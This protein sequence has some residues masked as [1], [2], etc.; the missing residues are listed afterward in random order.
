[1][2]QLVDVTGLRLQHLIDGAWTDGGADAAGKQ[3]AVSTNPANAD[4]VAT[5][6]EAT[7]ADLR[8]SLDAAVQA[9]REWSKAGMIRRGL[10]LR[11]AAE[12]LEQRADQVARLM[13]AEEGKTLPEARVE[14]G[15]SVE[16]LHYHAGQSRMAEGSI[17]PSSHPDE[18]I[19]TVRRPLGVVAVI[20]PW[21]FPVQI[22]VWKIAPALLW[23]NAVIWKPASETPA[24][25]VALAQVFLDA[26]VPAGVLNLLLAP[27]SLGAELVAAEEVAAVTF[28][29]S[30]P[31]GRSIAGVAIP[32]GARV[33]LELGGHNAAIVM[34]D[35]DP[36]VAA[37]TLVFGA[38]GSTGQKCTATRR[39]IAV[40]EMY[41]ALIPEL[42]KRVEALRV[43]DGAEGGVDIGPLISGRSRKDVQDAVDTAIQQGAE[44][45]ASTPGTPDGEAFF[46]PTV[47]TGPATMDI[48]REEVFGPVTTLLRAADLDE[49]IEL[50]NGTKFGL[51]ASI[52]SSDERTVRRCVEEIDAGLV[53]ANAPTT[54]SELHVPFGGTKASAFP[55]PREQNA[56]TAADF[57]TWSKSAYMRTAA[58]WRSA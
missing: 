47:L 31:V 27:G 6:R 15:A 23:G 32:R 26:G 41:D 49:A 55:A 57:F 4:V 48:A 53:K 19:R 45:V 22:P 33:Q 2:D 42:R 7:S 1:M 28:T 34:P 16:T 29:G 5:Y 39:I 52:F 44:V 25:S 37:E 40:G 46:A 24:V 18:L 50:A 54:G 14:V 38:M 9:Q 56:Q 43:G 21:N 13:T 11:R 12:L 58:P 30:V 51:T 8:R 36:A 17:F 10:V 20:T 3:D 35:V